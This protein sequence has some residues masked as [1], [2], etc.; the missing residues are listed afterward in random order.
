M[1]REYAL[2]SVPG[3]TSDPELPTRPNFEYKS[4]TGRP[5]ARVKYGARMGTKR[6]C[7]LVALV[8]L[9]V[10][11]LIPTAAEAR[12]GKRSSSGG[13]AASGGGYHGSSGGVSYG[14]R[15]SGP[16]RYSF[17]P[18]FYYGWG[19]GYYP[20][21]GYYPPY[22]YTPYAYPVPD[23]PVLVQRAPPPVIKT[24]ISA[25][26]QAFGNLD[27]RGYHSS[28]GGT[29]GAK[30]AFE[31][32]RLG[33][34]ARFTEIF[35]PREDRAINPGTDQIGLFNIFA[36]YAIIASPYGRLRVEGGVTS[37][38]APDLVVAGPG[39][40]VSAVV[41]LGPLGLEGAIH[42]TP[43]PY[44]ELDWNA[45]LAVNLGPVGFHGG[46]RRIFLDDRGLVDNVIH[47]DA[48]SGPYLGI[49]LTL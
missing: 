6:S 37:A 25:E 10:A 26:G 1:Y 8:L 7:V 9:F 28:D 33:V 5:L 2:A 12:F 4:E 38:F 45:G 24:T 15:F 43:W 46:W 11:A 19:F 27:S 44:R 17:A 31:G 39:G 47:K 18:S 23:Q 35:A 49:G 16:Y 41:G 32:R 14:S 13:G 42:G 22:Y 40:G 36:T 20:Y 21:F 3:A 34:T 48:F 29:V 30:L